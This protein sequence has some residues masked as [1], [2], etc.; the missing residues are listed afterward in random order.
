MDSKDSSERLVPESL[1]ADT[2]SPK[3]IVCQNKT[4]KQQGSPKILSTFQRCV[5]ANVSVEASG[6]LGQCGNGPMIIIVQPNETKDG[7]EESWHSGVNPTDVYAI[8][9]QH[10]NH[11]SPHSQ[12]SPQQSN[13]PNFLWFWA[14]GLL[15]FFCACIT[16]AI[17]FGGPS[18]YG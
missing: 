15:I 7:I 3:V 18:H 16:L 6:C 13:K 5:P 10:F 1:A 9:A 12:Q 8:A 17:V 14:V 4:C 11:E 2:S